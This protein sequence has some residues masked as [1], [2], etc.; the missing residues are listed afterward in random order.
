[1]TKTYFSLFIAIFFTV[2]CDT[3]RRPEQAANES[4]SDSTSVDTL[5]SSL[6]E[7]KIT[8]ADI[9]ITKSLQYDKYTLEDTYAYKDSTRMFQWDKI[10]EGLAE[11][12]NMQQEKA[13]WG[14][15]QNYKNRNGESPLVYTFRRNSY[16]R[17]TDTLDVERYQSVP[18][19]L[20]GDTV[21]PTRYGRDGWLVKLLSAD[22]LKMVRVEG[23]SFQ[24]TYDIPKRYLTKWGDTIRFEKVAAVDV[25]N[26]NIATL[27]KQD[28]EWL[29][30]SMNPVTTGRHLPP[31]AQETPT[32]LFAVLE[33]KVKMLYTKDGSSELAGYAPYA[34]RFSAGAYLHGFPT[35]SV[36]APIIE[37]SAS[38][39]T[40][41]RS[42]KC[43]RNASSH[44]KFMFDWINVGDALVF[45]ID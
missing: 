30:R 11:I 10:R 3:Q 21:S 13:V 9:Q 18:L 16:K 39:G 4:G 45:V 22:T 27:E 12:E 36:D 33:K 23:A 14:V 38:L 43:V 15:L 40:V 28:G 44:A 41:P 34:S 8:A 6:A 7:K 37:Y 31:Y 19:Y 20:P 35:N 5:S 1:M 29:V 26:Q 24:G 32:G 17:V 2:S 25:T 42:H